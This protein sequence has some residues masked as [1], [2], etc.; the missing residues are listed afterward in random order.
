MKK[1]YAENFEK[2]AS[3]ENLLEAWQEFLPGKRGKR[4]VQEFQLHLM[5]NILSLRADLVNGTYRHGGYRHFKI[6]DPK[7]RDIHKASVRDRLLHHAIYR[8]LYPFFDITFI[9]DS[10]SCRN[11]KGT[12][13]AMN[14][15]RAFGYIVG[16]NNTRTCWVL[17]CD[18]KKFFANVDHGILVEIL[19]LYISDQ[20]IMN[21]LKEVIRSFSSMPGVGLPLGN[22]TSQLLVNIYMNEFDQFMKHAIRAKHYLRYA[23]DFIILSSNQ[24]WLE[25]ILPEIRNFLANRLKLT[26]HP[27][28]VSIKTLASGVDV[29]GWVHF[30][31]HRVL[32]T[33]TKK[34]AIARVAAD[35]NE[36]RVASYLGM[37]KHGNAEKIRST[38]FAATP[39]ETSPYIFRN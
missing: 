34:R 21:L 4:D 14:R 24:E 22:L 29:L 18:V 30:P 2:I 12:H 6:S 3:A 35:P 7:P 9:A 36:Q 32:R 38:I 19:R 10:F 17:Q 15:F 23:D 11:A 27:D 37:L 5:D 20:R 39:E 26:L 13:A 31:D 28:K 25:I 8:Q 1:I 33:G 16:R